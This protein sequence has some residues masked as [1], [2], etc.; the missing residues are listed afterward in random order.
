MM[1]APDSTLAPREVAW[2]VLAQYWVDT[3]Y[4]EVEL[5]A[6][7]SRLLKTGLTLG[8]LD[9]IARRD[10][11]GAFATF[12]VAV[13][14]SAGMALPDWYYPEEEARKKVSAWLARPRLLSWL[15]PIWVVG[16]FMALAF[17]GSSWSGLRSK[18]AR[19]KITPAAT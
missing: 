4:D 9:A 14:L 7:A 11:C 17:L 6:F 16:Y 12:T 8:E 3:W 1:S 13:F 2:V 18:V 19:G 15:N 5:D 10:V